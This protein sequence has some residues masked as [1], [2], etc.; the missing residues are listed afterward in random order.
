[1]NHVQFVIIV[2]TVMWY[3]FATRQHKGS[4][5]NFAETAL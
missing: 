5:V 3:T 2:A 1:V 4:S